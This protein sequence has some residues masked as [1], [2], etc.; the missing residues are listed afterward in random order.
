MSKPKLPDPPTRT[1]IARED[2]L[3]GNL[4]P[5]QP[6]RV[7]IDP[8]VARNPFKA[9]GLDRAAPIEKRSA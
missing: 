2:H 1:L 3:Q 6:L 8:E 7:R 5:H 9:P 4:H